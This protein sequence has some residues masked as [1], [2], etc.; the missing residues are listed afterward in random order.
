MYLP[1]ITR[2]K[3]LGRNTP[4]PRFMET[5][6]QADLFPKFS[7]KAKRN[8]N[9]TL[10]LWVFRMAYT[11]TEYTLTSGFSDADVLAKLGEVFAGMGLMTSPTAWFDSFTDTSGSE[12]RIMEMAYT[13]NSGAYNKVYHAFFMG[14]TSPG[15]WYTTYYAWDVTT[16]QSGGL[17]NLDQV[18]SYKYPDST[19]FWS[20]YYV[21]LTLL[22]NVSDY[23]IITYEDGANA[24]IVRFTNSGESR[25]FYFVPTGS[26]LRGSPDYCFY[27]P[28]P[29]ATLK[30]DGFDYYSGAMM[31][32]DRSIT[33][34]S[35]PGTSNK[36]Q[37]SPSYGS[38]YSGGSLS[39]AQL[40]SSMNITSLTGIPSVNV[41]T[42]RSRVPFYTIARNPPVMPGY[43]DT[44][45]GS[46]FG[47]VSAANNNVFF[48]DFGDKLIVS[49]G[50]EEYEVLSVEPTATSYISN[51]SALLARTV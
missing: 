20:S 7:Q 48:P 11:R 12:V 38:H 45:F 50:V 40:G 24:S 30:I 3:Y 9:W 42:S 31:A 14:G 16:H 33:G 22:A 44:T 18:G 29:F 26:L 21:C 5:G 36:Y 15:L 28:A 2:Y 32:I 27:A 25:L 19:S 1:G 6:V 35:T 39:T 41:T 10:S 8:T 46:N 4:P 34:H 47:V 13:G 49:A 37:L 23:S 17:N 43:Y 51:W